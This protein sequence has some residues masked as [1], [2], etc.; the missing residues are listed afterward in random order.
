MTIQSWNPFWTT[1][2]NTS[3]A[4]AELMMCG[5]KGENGCG[6][7]GVDVRKITGHTE[8]CSCEIS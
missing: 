1:L 4:Y 2:P 7:I 5:C 6:A 8:L 3:K